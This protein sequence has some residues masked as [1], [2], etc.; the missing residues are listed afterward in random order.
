MKNF[1][2]NT[3]SAFKM[4]TFIGAIFTGLF[5]AAIGVS[6]LVAET[7]KIKEENEKKN[8]GTSGE[9]PSVSSTENKEK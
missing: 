6:N 8:A 1:S 5:G 2:N 3:N 7:N 9:A 4:G